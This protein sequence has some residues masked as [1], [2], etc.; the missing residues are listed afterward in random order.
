V[1][2]F[3]Q[4]DQATLFINMPRSIQLSA[5]R[6]GRCERYN[7]FTLPIVRLMAFGVKVWKRSSPP[8]VGPLP[9]GKRPFDL[10]RPR[11]EV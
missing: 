4:F 9:G 5:R 2:V 6:G 8:V 3:N 1:K 11:V 10:E 7:R